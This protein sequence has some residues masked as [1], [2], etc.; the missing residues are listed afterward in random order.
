VLSIGNFDGVHLGHQA[1]LKKLLER[2]REFQCPSLV[3]SFEPQPNEFF[4][5]YNETSRLMRLREKTQALDEFGV[6]RLLIGYFNKVFAEVSAEDFIRDYLVQRLGVR[7]IIVGDD[8]R[9]GYKRVGDWELL[10][11]EGERYGFTVEKM[12]ST[13]MEGQRVSSTL[14]RESLEKG[15]LQKAE[16]LLGRPYS[17]SGRVVHGDKLGRTLG[18]PTANI[19]LHRLY[20]PIQGIFAVL[21]D[22]LRSTP[23]KGVASVGTRPTVGGNKI[24]LEVHLFDFD[25]EIYGRHLR[26]N[27]VAKHR[28]EEKFSSLDE[29][30]SQIIKDVE[31]AR[32]V[33]A[34]K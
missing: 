15:D 4:Q 26:V 29:M 30:Q 10:K 17:F 6:D 11:A 19:Y 7:H 21:V 14:V 32:E 28:E 27:F 5:H 1:L 18:F 22:G 2:S 3:L 25:E 31:W 33:L 24:I 34:P 20:T 13:L 8:F 16:L 12:P 9:F 23:L